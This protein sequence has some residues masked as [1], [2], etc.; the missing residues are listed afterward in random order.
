[1]NAQQNLAKNLSQQ[2]VSLRMSLEEFSQELG[3]PKSTLHSILKTG[4]TTVNTLV[5]IAQHLHISIDALLGTNLSEDPS[6]P[7]MVFFPLFDC[8]SKLPAERQSLFRIYLSLLLE[9]LQK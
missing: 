1:M 2:R 8:Y 7:C 4:N 3:I 6:T 9:V 5:Q